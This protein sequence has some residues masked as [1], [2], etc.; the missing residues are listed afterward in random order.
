MNYS[1]RLE[2]LIA[3]SKLRAEREAEGRRQ[4]PS[5][6][7]SPRTPEMDNAESERR[8]V[9]ELERIVADDATHAKVV[10]GVLLGL[11]DKE[12]LAHE[13][14]DHARTVRSD[15]RAR[16]LGIEV[17]RPPTDYERR[18]A[19]EE[20]RQRQLRGERVTVDPWTSSPG[21]VRR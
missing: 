7:A 19:A 8:A 15:G 6:P 16:R 4:M 18:L 9:R 21:S 13:K 17:D 20:L 5:L 2:S 10:D 12:L 11:T 3:S 1:D 14:L